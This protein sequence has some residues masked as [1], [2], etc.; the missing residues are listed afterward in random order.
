VQFQIIDTTLFEE[1]EEERRRFVVPE[2]TGKVLKRLC[3]TEIGNIEVIE[4]VVTRRIW[5]LIAR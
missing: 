5:W 4:S 1:G 2:K 3:P